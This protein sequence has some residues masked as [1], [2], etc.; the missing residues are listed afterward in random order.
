MHS[1]THSLCILLLLV[2]IRDVSPHP[3]P[4]LYVKEH[5]DFDSIFTNLTPE[6]LGSP[7]AVMNSI[8]IGTKSEVS[9]FIQIT[10]LAERGPYLHEH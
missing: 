1:Y 6:I 7:V 5:Q 3:G 4:V 8:D 2:G 9:L 10:F